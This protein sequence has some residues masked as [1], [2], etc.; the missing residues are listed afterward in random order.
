MNGYSYD[1][2][3][4]RGEAVTGTLEAPD[5]ASAAAEL[6]AR[7]LYPTELRAG[8]STPVAATQARGG[9][10]PVLDMPVLVKS[11]DVAL[12]LSQLAL[13]LRSGLTLSFALETLAREASN[14]AL[15]A[16]AA[17]LSAAVQAGKT[18]SEGL[19]QEGRLLPSI[20]VRLVR[21]AEVTG[22]LEQAFDRAA[23]FIER[24]AA[25]RQRLIASLTYPL[26][27]LLAAS[28]VFV[29]MTTQ[30]VPKFA[31]FLARRGVSLPWTTQ[32]L[33]DI[34]ALLTRHGPALVAGL[35]AAALGLWLTWRSARGGRV[36]ERIALAV[37]VLGA[38]LQAA[39][40]GH[41]LRTLGLLLRSGLP[42]L[43]SLQALGP[44][45]TLRC[46]GDLLARA[47][48]RVVAGSTLAAALRDPLVPGLGTQ[49]VAVGE[50]TGSL[51]GV[52]SELAEFYERRLERLLATLA[53]LV[54]PALLVVIGGMVGFV[55]LS[56]FQAVFRLAGR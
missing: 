36:L 54:E 32:L 29:F 6:R 37:P 27:V 14:R 55:Y 44:V 24:R 17:R 56:F 28:G 4:G 22:E 2:L 23:D 30:V 48:E 1:A 35:A 51:D 40:L 41:L 42:L 39:A 10:L 9:W 45:A 49:V 20:V 26:I 25:L 31:T 3:D 33:M 46:Y 38:T 19:E 47:R 16:C 18:L 11:S 5:E 8:G 34:S 43:E 13:M 12:F 50:Q 53:A 15:A 52:V 21:T 7:G